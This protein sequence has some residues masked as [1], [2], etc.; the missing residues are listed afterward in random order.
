VARSRQ[1]FAA[2]AARIALNITLLL[3]SA[4]LVSGQQSQP[5]Q[6]L[7]DSPSTT[8]ANKPQSTT[9]KNGATQ[10]INLLSSKSRAFPNLAV[11]TK[12]LTPAE[13]FQLAVQ[14]SISPITVIGTAAGAGFSQAIDS[15]S[16][17]GQGAEGYFKRWGGN[18]AY[19]SSANL[20][21]TFA[22]ATALHQDPRYFVRNS[23]KFKQS[24]RY[25][26]SRV[27]VARYDDGHTGANWATLLGP[28]GAATLANTYLPDGSR[29]VGNTFANWGTSLAIVAGVNILREYWPHINK[30]IGLPSMGVDNSPNTVH[31]PQQLA[32]AQNP[33]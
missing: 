24:V 13:K 6:R 12:P 32:P 15:R 20:I 26:V 31:S 3:A 14:N 2:N 4:C 16:G 19:A 25:A 21:G 28:L 29:G 23:G 7:P 10:F 33:K 22:I 18:M 11:S 1:Q 27:F 30:K 9:E 8:S 5:S 17:Y